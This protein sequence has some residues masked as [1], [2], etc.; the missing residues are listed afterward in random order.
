MHQQ[1]HT[2]ITQNVCNCRHFRLTPASIGRCPAR[3]W[4]QSSGFLHHSGVRWRLGR[5]QRPTGV[6]NNMSSNRF[7]RLDQGDQ[8]PN[9][10]HL[11]DEEGD[12]RRPGWAPYLLTYPAA[13]WKRKISYPNSAALMVL[14]GHFKSGFGS[15][16]T[17]RDRPGLLQ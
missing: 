3:V 13:T 4:R 16:Y 15:Q 7:C 11:M 6:K 12:S 1:I 2:V 5:H 14:G 17:L 10:T 9:C 8:A